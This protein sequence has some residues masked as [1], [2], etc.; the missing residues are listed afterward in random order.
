MTDKTANTTDVTRGSTLRAR[1]E[2]RRGEL[3]RAL[4]ELGPNDR[5]RPDLEVALQGVKSL[6]IGD[7]DRIPYVVASELNS[8]LEENKH[9]ILRHAEPAATAQADSST[10]PAAVPVPC[11]DHVSAPVSVADVAVAVVE[12]LPDVEPPTVGGDAAVVAGAPVIIGS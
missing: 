8:W 6:L 11:A 2:I 12:I 7:L 4:A 1:V 5:G 3:E 9:M 10:A